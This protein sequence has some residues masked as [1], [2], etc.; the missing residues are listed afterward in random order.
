ME[1]W[2]FKMKAEWRHKMKT[3]WTVLHQQLSRIPVQV[4]IVFKCSHFAHILWNWVY[5][6]NLTTQH[7]IELFWSVNPWS[8]KIICFYHFT[9]TVV[10]Q[11]VWVC[12]CNTQ[13]PLWCTWN[14][15]TVCLDLDILNIQSK[16]HCI[17]NL[18]RMLSLIKWA[19]WKTSMFTQLIWSQRSRTNTKTKTDS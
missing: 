13:E 11:T 19:C 5:V 18:V 16:S 10:Q 12:T 7:H 1:L 15:G 6:R 17:W 8:H 2:I 14:T 4:S 3:L 9:N